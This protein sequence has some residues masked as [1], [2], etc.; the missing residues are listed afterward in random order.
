MAVCVQQS[1]LQAGAESY[2][3]CGFAGSA[4]MPLV[5][6]VTFIS[7]CLCSSRKGLNIPFTNHRR[8][9][10]YYYYLFFDVLDAR[11][12]CAAFAIA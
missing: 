10:I 3:R 5:Y 12:V 8:Q 11:S 9:T 2:G 4:R 1:D 6:C 7:P